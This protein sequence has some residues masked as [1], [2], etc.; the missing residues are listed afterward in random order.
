MFV[1]LP[2]ITHYAHDKPRL[3]PQTDRLDLLLQHPQH[4]RAVTRF[5]PSELFQLCRDLLINAHEK[6]RGNW[7][8]RP[9]H[10]LMLALFCL[11]NSL[12]LRKGRHVFGW[13]SGSLSM[14]LYHWVDVIVDRLDADDS[15]TCSSHTASSATLALLSSSLHLRCS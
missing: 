9:L 1:M 14:N 8:F 7:R 5:S 10:R 13:A 3:Q 11:G 12:T 6:A 2:L 4:C 15:R